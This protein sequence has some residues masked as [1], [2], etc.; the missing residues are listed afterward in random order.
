MQC[1]L[2]LGLLF[3]EK[4]LPLSLISGLVIEIEITSTPSE[5][6]AEA[7]AN[8]DIEDVYLSATCMNVDSALHSSYAAHVLSGKP[9]H[10]NFQSIAVTRHILTAAQFTLSLARNY[11]R[12]KQVYVTLHS[13]ATA[14]PVKD[15][16]HPI[17]AN[18]VTTANDTLQYQL[19]IGTNRWPERPVAGLGETFMRLKQAAGIFLGNED[20]SIL[21]TDF[22]NAKAVYAIDLEKVG[23]A[24]T[25]LR[26]EHPGRTPDS[27]IFGHRHGRWS[28]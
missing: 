8:W 24:A 11:T 10:L 7:G 3:Q 13:S 16:S 25:L 21:P 12:L 2:S 28:G 23:A 1:P 6:F 5:C 22:H 20:I 9:L 26:A 17:G 18:G 19:T 4:W 27:R 15:F 14:K